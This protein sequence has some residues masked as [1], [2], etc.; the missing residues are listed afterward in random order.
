MRRSAAAAGSA[1]FFGL[2]PGVVAG[3]IPRAIT[4]W[5]F[6]GG[7]PYAIGWIGA[8]LRVAGALLTATGFAVL[9][10][11]FVRFVVEGLGTPAP[12][13]PTDRLVVGG[14]YAHIRNPMY[15]AVIA[16]IL[17]QALLFG[18][19]ALLVWAIVAGTAMVLFAKGYEEPTLQR[20]F[21]PAYEAYRRAVPGW[22]P[23]LRPWQPDET[24]GA[25]ET[26]GVD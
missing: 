22:W 26:D 17:G 20:Q 24:S 16:A 7:G 2:A 4:G 15:A 21:G 18:S 11:A 6:A 9:V 23:R 8:P 10:H 12:V 14:I 1:L 5:R 19:L 13:A 3:I 25:R